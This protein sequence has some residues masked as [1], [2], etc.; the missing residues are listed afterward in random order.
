MTACARA[1]LR[2]C[3]LALLLVGTIFHCERSKLLMRKAEFTSSCATRVRCKP[4][5]LAMGERLLRKCHRC[6]FSHCEHARPDRRACHG[7]CSVS[8]D[9]LIALC[10]QY[11]NVYPPAVYY[12]AIACGDRQMWLF[13]GF[14]GSPIGVRICVAHP[15]WRVVVSHHFSSTASRGF[16]R[17]QRRALAISSDHQPIRLECVPISVSISCAFAFAPARCCCVSPVCFSPG[18]VLS[19][20]LELCRRGC[21]SRNTR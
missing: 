17:P 3:T 20:R 12:P 18:A 4:A 11:A 21:Q 5:G 6:G 15:S 13:G 7:A 14:Q 16:R 8:A 19:G 10:S 1:A 2:L 9:R